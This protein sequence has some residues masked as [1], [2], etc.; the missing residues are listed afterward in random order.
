M[1][2]DV[3]Q[4]AGRGADAELDNGASGA[5]A[6]IVGFSRLSENAWIDDVASRGTAAAKISWLRS[7]SENIGTTRL[8]RE[9]GFCPWQSGAN[10]HA[11][12][13]NQREARESRCSSRVALP[14][15][16]R[17]VLGCSHRT[18]TSPTRALDVSLASPLFGDG[19]VKPHDIFRRNSHGY[20]GRRFGAA[21][22]AAGGIGHA[23]KGSPKS[24]ARRGCASDACAER[25]S[26]PYSA[27]LSEAFR[28]VLLSADRRIVGATRSKG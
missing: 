6:G 10:G 2:D 25:C 17:K 20:A 13:K 28:S 4:I 16:P 14:G 5:T 9:T 11:C 8:P 3:V 7:G 19:R 21:A 1:A 15:S 23:P 24:K 18:L 12:P 26:R 27:E 22:R